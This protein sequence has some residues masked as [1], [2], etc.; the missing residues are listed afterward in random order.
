MLTILFYGGIILVTGLLWKYKNTISLKCKKYKSLVRSYREQDPTMYFIT[1]CI[2]AFMLII[3][4][5]LLSFYQS[6]TSITIPNYVL[7]KYVWGGKYYNHTIPIRKGPKPEL[8]YGYIDH[9]PMTEVIG[10]LS[11]LQRDFSGHPE[12][13]LEFGNHIR[14]KFADRDEIIL[15]NTGNENEKK[16]NLKKLKT[17]YQNL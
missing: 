9:I 11:G 8:E 12:M 1:A 15:S 5:S 14:Y 16:E 7:V 10:Q 2:K 13:L 17:F 3:H 6:H 4:C